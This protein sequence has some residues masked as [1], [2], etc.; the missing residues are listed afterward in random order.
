M[1]TANISPLERV[2]ELEESLLRLMSDLNELWRPDRSV[3]PLCCVEDGHRAT[4]PYRTAQE[5]LG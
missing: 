4:C 3:C 5:L 1:N 2:A